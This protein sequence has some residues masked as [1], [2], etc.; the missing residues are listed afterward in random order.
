MLQGNPRLQAYICGVVHLACAKHSY[1]S[2]GGLLGSLWLGYKLVSLSVAQY[3]GI[4]PKLM[5]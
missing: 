4:K 2:L 3:L 1:G 5:R